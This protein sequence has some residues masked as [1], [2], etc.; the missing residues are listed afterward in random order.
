MRSLGKSKTI[1]SP[2]A[3]ESG[4]SKTRCSAGCYHS[5]VE[6]FYK[7]LSS[8]G[9]P[10]MS[11]HV[12]VRRSQVPSVAWRPE[13][14]SG[15]IY[16]H[17]GGL[18]TLCCNSQAVAKVPKSCVRR[19]SSKSLSLL[20]FANSATDH[21]CFVAFTFGS[22]GSTCCMRSSTRFG[23]ARTE[24]RPVSSRLFEKNGDLAKLSLPSSTVDC[25]LPPTL[26]SRKPSAC[27]QSSICHRYAGA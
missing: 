9:A 21:T 3:V 4:N 25:E 11:G 16:R 13:L 10:Q 19:R 8:I 20:R 22:V 6:I 15:C 27:C 5:A 7:P 26:S 2:T 18:L 24:E 17:R 23:A 1:S 14:L 12:A